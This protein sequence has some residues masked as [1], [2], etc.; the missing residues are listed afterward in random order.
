MIKSWIQFTNDMIYVN[1]LVLKWL[2]NLFSN[3]QYYYSLCKIELESQKIEWVSGY[4]E[5]LNYWL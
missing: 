2:Q 3:M 1:T 4:A 5:Y